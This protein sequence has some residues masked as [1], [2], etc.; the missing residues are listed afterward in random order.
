MDWEEFDKMAAG[1]FSFD[2]KLLASYGLISQDYLHLMVRFGY[3][4]SVV[5]SVCSSDAGANYVNFRFKGGGAGFDQ[6]LLRLEFI[7]QVL[8]RYG[9]ETTTRGDMIDAKC[10]RM[11]ENDTRKLL[12][13]LGYLMAVTRLMDMRMENEKQVS[14][15]V[16][17]F[18]NEAEREKL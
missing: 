10:T 1:I 7:R 3:H 8:D 11:S 15:E 18:I 4:F 2:S 12:A 13:R 6:R 14:L 5:D 9:F 17:K 16:E